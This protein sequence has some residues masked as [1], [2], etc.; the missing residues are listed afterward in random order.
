MNAARRL[1]AA[2][3]LASLAAP[4][5]AAGEGEGSPA[6]AKEAPAKAPAA[7]DEPG[8][9]GGPKPAAAKQGDAAKAGAGKAAAPAPAAA[10]RRTPRTKREA[11]AVLDSLELSVAW[12]DLPL[13]DAV[14][15]L[16]TVT[17]VNLVLGPA[18]LKEGD[19]DVRKVTLKLR[20]V[21]A[22]QVLEFLVEG[23]GL[24]VGFRTGVLLVT[25][26]KEARGAPVLKLHP[27]GDFTF[28]LRDFPGPEMELRPAGAE[29]A[30]PERTETKHPFS[31]LEEIVALIK[32][33]TG[34]GTWEDEGVSVST[35]GEWIV[36]RQYEDVQA[37]VAKLLALL[38]AAR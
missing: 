13:R 2:F 35:M 6:P 38:R 11:L 7:K 16:S 17:G 21:T 24:A 23:Q 26:V 37:E 22:K 33:N 1:A 36:V 20:G 30:E 19:L 27:A 18:L 4:A 9:S 3:V 14:E 29:T 10:A 12:E 32:D 5:A 34:S 31:D 8:K 15:H 28:V 25:T